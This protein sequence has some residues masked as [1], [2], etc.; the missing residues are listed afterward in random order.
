LTALFL[1]SGEKI[2]NGE[3]RVVLGDSIQTGQVSLRPAES[4]LRFSFEFADSIKISHSWIS[5]FPEAQEMFIAG[6]LGMYL[7]FASEY[8][9]MKNKNPHL[10]LGVAHLPILNG[11]K[12]TYGSLFAPSVPLASRNYMASW[13]FIKFL[14]GKETSKLYSDLKKSASP[15]RDLFASYQGE[16]ARSVFAESNLSLVSWPNPDPIK[17]NTIFEELIENM[18]LK[19]DTM[20]GLLEKA[21]NQ[22][23]EIKK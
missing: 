15:R 20:R 17:T 10:A 1:Q 22:L 11:Q 4:A 19:K 9:E 6:R 18:A 2:I 13:Q 3:G 14:T 8:E 5:S 21:A 23:R 16:P 12:A 7:G